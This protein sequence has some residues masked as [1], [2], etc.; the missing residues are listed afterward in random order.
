[1][2]GKKEQHIIYLCISILE[3]KSVNNLFISYF[4]VYLCISI[5]EFK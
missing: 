3:F 1:M 4:K 2:A 5:L